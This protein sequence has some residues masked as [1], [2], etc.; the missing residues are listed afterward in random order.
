MVSSPPFSSRIGHVGSHS[1]PPD[2][3]VDPPTYADFS[4]I[5]TFRPRSAPASAAA[6]PVPEP[7]TNKSTVVSRTG[8]PTGMLPSRALV[9]ILD[10]KSQ[11]R[12]R[13]G[14]F[15]ASGTVG[16]ITGAAVVEQGHDVAVGHLRNRRDS[17]HRG[18]SGTD[19]IRPRLAL[20]GAD[21]GLRRRQA[22][23]RARLRAEAGGVPRRRRQDQC[24]RRLLPS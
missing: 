7:I 10:S 12:S 1:A 8:R 9:M 18:R 22:T 4:A 2:R 13:G 5:S 14:F 11:D 16:S 3:A 23:R 24:A 15:P 19:E 21:Q 6:M 17:A 20:S